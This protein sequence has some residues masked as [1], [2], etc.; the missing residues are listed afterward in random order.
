M[1]VPAR[2]TAAVA[3]RPALQ[4]LKHRAEIALEKR[5]G[6][7]VVFSKNLSDR[8]VGVTDVSFE[9]RQNEK[10]V[11]LYFTSKPEG[12]LAYRHAAAKV[13]HI[14]GVDLQYTPQFG[15]SR[16]SFPWHTFWALAETEQLGQLS[17]RGE[18]LLQLTPR[19]LHDAMDP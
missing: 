13:S 7:V 5:S 2:G 10:H 8:D 9:H 11:S 3:L 14:E 6:D 4:A 1:S 16:I 17:P 12:L 19:D 15:Q 18:P